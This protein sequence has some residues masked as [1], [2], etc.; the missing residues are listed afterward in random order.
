MIRC[1]YSDGSRHIPNQKFG[2]DHL[3]EV[4]SAIDG[5]LVSFSRTARS[6]MMDASLSANCPILVFMTEVNDWRL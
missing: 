2:I 4:R 5:R 1:N 3:S 6:S